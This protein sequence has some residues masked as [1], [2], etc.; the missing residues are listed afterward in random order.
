MKFKRLLP[1]AIAASLVLTSQTAYAKTSTS[2]EIP[3]LYF[4][5]DS[6]IHVQWDNTSA[7]FAD[8]TIDDDC[9]AEAVAIV[10]ATNLSA[11]ITGELYIQKK[12]GSRW[13]RV[14]TWNISGTGD[15]STSRTYTV[16]S[17]ETYRSRVVVDVE[18][19]GHSEHI[20]GASGEVT[21]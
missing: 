3:K 21:A 14:K 9:V 2:T 17:G 16:V 5:E 18:Y 19:N 8:L 13:T 10:K 20:Y 12:V 11:K 7:L 15:I 6:G 1:A 4:S